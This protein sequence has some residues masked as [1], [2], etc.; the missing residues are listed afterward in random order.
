[1]ASISSLSILIPLL[2]GLFFL[3]GLNKPQKYLLLYICFSTIAEAIS[4]YTATHGIKNQ[5]LFK[6]LLVTDLTFFSW[7]FWDIIK[8]SLFQCISII[9][10]VLIIIFTQVFLQSNLDKYDSLFFVTLFFF[11]IIQSGYLIIVSFDNFE[12][13]IL[14]N[15]IFWVATARLFYF[16]IIVFIY[17]YPSMIEDGYTNK[18]YGD[19]NTLINSIANIILNILYSRA[20]YV[21]N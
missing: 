3:K 9:I 18:I 4:Y 20:L 14:D 7:L 2:L 17:V 6:I 11:F 12:M 5:W 15:F 10:V 13:N 19:A 8:V 16:L 1:V 21:R